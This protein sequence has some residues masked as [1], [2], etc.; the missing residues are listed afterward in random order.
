MSWETNATPRRPCLD[1]SGVEPRL[2]GRF[3][4]SAL[5]VNTFMVICQVAA[6]PKAL[7]LARQGRPRW[8]RASESTSQKNTTFWHKTG[9]QNNQFKDPQTCIHLPVYGDNSHVDHL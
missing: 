5:K 6:P 1:S 2:I 3:T 4:S 8:A 7:V 9:E